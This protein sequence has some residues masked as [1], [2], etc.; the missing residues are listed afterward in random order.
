MHA[1][2][3]NT[4]VQY[5]CEPLPSGTRFSS[6]SV[7]H[8][9]QR[10][11]C[12]ADGA[13]EEYHFVQWKVVP[14]RLV[15]AVDTTCGD[16]DKGYFCS[17][18][19]FAADF[20]LVIEG[21]LDPEG[22]P[23]SVLPRVD[24]VIRPTAAGAGAAKHV[25][26]V[27]DFGNSRTGALLIEPA[28]KGGRPLM[29]PFELINRHHLDAWDE[30]GRFIKKHS[31]RWFNSRTQWCMSPYLPPPRLEHK[32]YPTTPSQKKG[33]F[34]GGSP[35]PAVQT[36]FV[37]PRLFQDLSAV[38]MGQEG[39]DVSQSMRTEGTVL[40]GVSSP[41]RYLWADD[42]SW[43]QGAIWHMADPEDRCGTHNY[44]ATLQGP[45]LRYL[46][47]DDPD[48]LDL[49][50]LDEDEVSDDEIAREVPHKPRHVPRSL[51]VAALYELLCQAYTYVNSSD[52]RTLTG[53]PGRPRELRSLV[54]TYPSGMISQECERL[55]RQAQKAIDAFRVTLGRSQERHPTLTLSIDEA[56]AV[57]LT[58]IWSELQMVDN[59]PRLWFSLV[60]RHRA[61]KEEKPSEPEATQTQTPP[62]P[63]G[64]RGP[65]R[66]R[67][68]ARRVSRVT[69]EASDQAHQEIR[70][71]CI[72]IGGGT[73]D[74]MIA[75]YEL[76]AGT[77]DTITGQMLHRDG[78][79]LAG[80]QLVKRL[81]ERIVVPVFADCCGMQTDEVDKL[82][83]QA[84]PWNRTFK[85]QRIAW[86]NRLFVPLAQ[87]Y[88]QHAVD[89]NLNDVIS[90][91]DPEYVDPDIVES[92]QKTVDDMFG[93]GNISVS[94]DLGLVYDPEL[95]E[96]VVHEVF[97]ELLIDF[98]GRIVTQDVDIVLLAGQPTKLRCIQDMVKR[99]LPLPPSRIVPMYEHFAG[100]WYPYQDE[101]GR[102]PGV[103]VDPKS[104][105]VVGA[106]VESLMT[107]GKL[108]AIRFRM[109]D[110]DT[111]T[112]TAVN[113]YHW[114]IMDDSRIR[115]DHVLFQPDDSTT[116]KEF[117]VVSERL[118]IGRRLS[119]D[120]RAEA[121]PVWMLKVD[122]EDRDG[123]IDILVTLTRTQASKDR[124]EM[125]EL[126]A[127]K[128]DVAGEPANMHDPDP[129]VRFFWRTLADEHFY[130]DTGALDNIELE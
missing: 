111:G 65:A 31:A 95:F 114:G 63:P 54:L 112:K 44:A 119:G 125:L 76:A 50:S 48:E 38:R 10:C 88:L 23:L 120:E 89:N 52:Y 58:Y 97:D 121:T 92:L 37:T 91:M 87:A 78:I 34:F 19:A 100:T 110:P 3:A 46:A 96:D 118:I 94:Q 67:P 73:S 107:K 83:G 72:D 85:A 55:R 33:G 99:Y 74:L 61:A 42:D 82:F 27:I 101:Q 93:G 62:G 45:L 53:D 9:W 51:M 17:A 39:E 29:E 71:A 64:L 7:G 28:Q 20:T 24:V 116:K 81:L 115:D 80:D 22:S 2:F 25:H 41:K 103:I 26:M 129:N 14:N 32:I 117:E 124:Q 43:L 69:T 49:P 106:A 30:E 15:L 122:R 4:G 68:A 66:R 12:Q 56:S 18:D 60:G 90:H 8:G 59:D 5:V 77:V 86:I 104:A 6:A 1:L 123:P 16:P 128:G 35:K 126:T 13:K 130:L 36:V 108:G 79:S 75:K 40:A 70:I 102:N 105:V 98:C 11:V 57:H 21:L 113:Q 127:V 47:E 84:R 109:T